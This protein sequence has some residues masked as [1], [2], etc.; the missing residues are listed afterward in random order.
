M[1]VTILSDTCICYSV[2]CLNS[3]N[4]FVETFY[5]YDQVL[6]ES[7]NQ[8]NS[9]DNVD[10]IYMLKGNNCNTKLLYCKV[11]RVSNK[12]WTLEGDFPL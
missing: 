7:F 3:Q 8:E 6:S 1:F 11:F 5:E 4:H 2:Y 9:M 12:D 10:I